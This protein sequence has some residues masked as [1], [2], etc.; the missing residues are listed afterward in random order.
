MESA[1]RFKRNYRACLNCRVRKVKCDLGPVDNPRDGKCLRCL[2]E[3]K[4]CVF[5]ESRRSSGGPTG[6]ASSSGGNVAASGSGNAYEGQVISTKLMGSPSPQ[7]AA[8]PPVRSGSN[9]IAQNNSNI[10]QPQPLQDDKNPRQ[11]EPGGHFA[12][13]EGALV[14]LAK[15][16]GTIAE[17][18]ERDNIDAQKKLEQIESSYNNSE[19]DRE[20]SNNNSSSNL[21]NTG[22]DSNNSKSGT[23]NNSLSNILNPKSNLSSKSPSL[24]GSRENLSHSRSSGTNLKNASSYPHPQNMHKRRVMPLAEKPDMIRPRASNKLSHF[25]YIGE[26]N[27]IL[28]E[29]EAENLINLFFTTMHPYFPFIPKYL[30]SPKVL[31]GY[32]ILLCSIL[33]ISSRYHPLSDDSSSNSGAVPR[34]IEVHDRLWLYV[35]RLI[36]Q[37]VWAEASTRSIGTVFAFLLFTE[38]NPRAIH[39]RW[40]DYAN[41]AE[42]VGSSMKD[43]IG[44][45]ASSGSGSAGPFG[46]ENGNEVETNMPGLGATRRS[47]RMAWMLIGSAVRLAQD[48]G[49]MEVSPKTFLATHIA[50]INSVMNIS[51]RSMLA[52]SLS[53]LDLDDDDDEVDEDEENENEDID[54]SFFEEVSHGKKKKDQKENDDSDNDHVFINMNEKELS[55]YSMSCSALKFT[56][57]QKAKIELLQ[58][59]SLG[60]ESL[61]GYKAQLGSLSQRQNLSILNILSPILKNWGKKY[62]RFLVVTKPKSIN[63]STLQQ[64]LLSPGSK[65]ANELRIIIDRESLIFEYNYTKLYIY[66]LALS[67]SPQS[68]KKNGK[69]VNGDNTSK[70]RNRVSLKLDEISKAAVFIE[71]AYTAA[72]EMLHSVQRIHRFRML[73]YMPVRWLTRIVRAI[74]F[75]VKCYLTITA[76][77]RTSANNNATKVS[78]ANSFDG[79]DSTVLSLSLIS[80]EDIVVTIQKAAITL[81]DCSPDELHLCTRYSNILMYLCSDM[82]SKMKN[83]NNGAANEYPLNKRARY[84]EDK[85]ADT[86]QQQQESSSYSPRNDPYFVDQTQ[87]S[88]SAAFP[89]QADQFYN[90]IQSGSSQNQARGGQYQQRDENQINLD[91]NSDFQYKDDSRAAMTNGEITNNPLPTSG[92]SKPLQGEREN[93]EDVSPFQTMVGDSEVMEWFVNNRDVGLDFVGPW[94]EMIEQHLDANQFNFDEAMN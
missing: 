4:D 76:H 64:Y 68:E 40:S 81:R 31:A 41:K 57:M 23:I 54:E 47:Y 16:A 28:S 8:S 66:S 53:E 11:D 15:A 84:E 67:P 39:W 56:P 25:D 6:S 80:I 72:N 24:S 7:A 10:H 70:K 73:K 77:N 34:N 45:T 14:F 5:V 21:A 79:Y 17:A 87:P 27:G 74:A 2:R 93:R 3:R 29:F 43:D 71:Q 42:D 86:F 89:L 9:V 12:T 38:W 78:I 49:F 36:S 50:E 26:P 44:N 69:G 59:M 85:I 60:H 33:T 55:D 58:I 22:V 92:Y 35:Q 19:S 91:N 65:I 48:M 52:H 30:H 37:T 20:V 13:M 1:S 32:P 63:L 90:P 46:T 82:K 75:V 61:Y 83:N 94:T 18:D 88:Q 62:K 51:R